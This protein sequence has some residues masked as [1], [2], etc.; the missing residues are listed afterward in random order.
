MPPFLN[1]SDTL[2]DKL[3]GQIWMTQRVLLKV[4]GLYNGTY[5]AGQKNFAV[6]LSFQKKMKPIHTYLI[7]I[8]ITGLIMVGIFWVV[9]FK[10]RNYFSIFCTQNVYL[11]LSM[12][13]GGQKISSA[14]VI[15]HMCAV[16]QPLGTNNLTSHVDMCQSNCVCSYGSQ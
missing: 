3:H 7:V 13:N 9:N 1:A 15:S 16:K 12:Y 6:I 14:T 8:M 11:R 2:L 10:T 5:H 4:C